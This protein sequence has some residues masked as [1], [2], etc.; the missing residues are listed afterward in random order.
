MSLRFAQ[1]VNGVDTSTARRARQRCRAWWIAGNVWPRSQSERGSRGA[2]IGR[3][4]YRSRR[5][6]HYS[7]PLTR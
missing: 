5:R 7:R 2:E 6:M 1:K 3:G 4:H